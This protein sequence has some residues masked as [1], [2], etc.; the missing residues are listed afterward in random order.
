[1]LGTGCELCEFC[2]LFPGQS[3]Q[4]H[5]HALSIYLPIA[6]KYEKS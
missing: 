3:P 2:E 5:L 6:A 1:M 4:H